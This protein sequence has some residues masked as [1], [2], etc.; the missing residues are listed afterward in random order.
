MGGRNAGC[1]LAIKEA[2]DASKI[3]FPYPRVVTVTYAPCKR[4]MHYAEPGKRK[5]P[6]SRTEEVPDWANADEED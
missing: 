5:F 2:F 4:Q 1:G 6:L 3:E